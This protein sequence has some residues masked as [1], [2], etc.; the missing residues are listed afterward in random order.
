M[1]DYRALTIIAIIFLGFPVYFLPAFIAAKR[2]LTNRK[3]ILYWNLFTAWTVIGWV[4]LICLAAKGSA[5]ES[6]VQKASNQEEE[7]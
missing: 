2:E 6:A 7:K 4:I 3:K 5:L 1:G